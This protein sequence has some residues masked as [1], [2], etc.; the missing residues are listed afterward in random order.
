MTFEDKIAEYQR[1]KREKN[2]LQGDADRVSEF[3]S[4]P[5]EDPVKNKELEKI[6]RGSDVFITFGVWGAYVDKKDLEG[7]LKTKK[8]KALADISK[9]DADINKL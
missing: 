6:T 4:L 5:G 7:L 8:N 2:S 3:L 1:L 9:I